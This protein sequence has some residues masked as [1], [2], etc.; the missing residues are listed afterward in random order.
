LINKMI[1]RHFAVKSSMCQ[2]N[3]GTRELHCVWN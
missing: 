1:I 2:W 3:K